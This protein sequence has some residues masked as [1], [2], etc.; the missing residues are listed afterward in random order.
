MKQ[1]ESAQTVMNIIEFGE[2]TKKQIHE[3]DPGIEDWDVFSNTYWWDIIRYKH[4]FTKEDIN[5]F[6]MGWESFRE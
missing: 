4:N 5:N 6:R 3:M 1:V 2:K